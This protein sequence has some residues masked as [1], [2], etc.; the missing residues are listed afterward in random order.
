MSA[1]SLTDL[2]T[3]A[4]PKE[5]LKVKLTALMAV[6]P[7][8]C[9]Q[10]ARCTSGCTAFRLLELKP[11]EIVGSARLGFLEELVSSTTIWDCALCLK[12]AERCPQGISAAEL[13]LALRNEAV[14]R[15]LEVPGRLSAILM[16]VMERGLAFEPRR[17]VTRDGK[18]FGREEL[19]LP[20]LDVGLSEEALMALMELLGGA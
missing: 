6:K 11:H 19:G 1:S 18:A 17:A 3:M 8:A 4:K 12:C 2:M 10:C 13:I 16:S 5:E 9:L 20:S 7:D 15:G 14:S